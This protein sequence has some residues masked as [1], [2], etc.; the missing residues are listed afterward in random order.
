MFLSL[1]YFLWFNVLQ[2]FHA[3]TDESISFFKAECS[4]G[5][6]GKGRGENDYQI[7]IHLSGT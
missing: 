7:I 5:G 1:G 6:A 4:R 2:I 3:A